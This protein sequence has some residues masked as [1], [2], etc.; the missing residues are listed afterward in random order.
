VLSIFDAAHREPSAPALIEAGSVATYADVA[1]GAAAAAGFLVAHGVTGGSGPI[2]LVGSSDRPTLTVLHALIALRTPALLV[3]PRLTEPEREALLAAADVREFLEPAACR[4]AAIAAPAPELPT[5]RADDEH[6]LAIVFTSGTT[7]TP[8]GVVLS[9]RSF[10]ASARASAENL[11]WRPDDRWLLG[12]GI[13]HVGGLGIVTRC[14]LARR[15][16]V[17][18]P[19][20]VFD[21]AAIVE[22]I[23][24]DRVTLMS[25]VPTQLARL[26]DL[27]PKWRPP[28]HL[29]AL[30][31]GGAAAP[32]ALLERARE[33][34]I[35]VLT[36]YGSSETCSQVTTQRLGTP[37]GVEQGAGHPLS[38]I[39]VAIVDN[40]IRVRG[41][42]LLSGYLSGEAA[43]LEDG[44]LRT[45]DFGQLDAEGRLHVLGR[46]DE[47]IVTGGEKVHPAEVERVLEAFAGVAA[48]CAC[49]IAD[50]TWGEIV[51]AAVVPREGVTLDLDALAAWARER[52][53]TFKRPRQLLEVRELP[54]T[55][56]GKLD[57]AAVARMLSKPSA[58]A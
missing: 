54:T 11:G 47:R 8:R 14:L 19:P 36:T 56:Q 2:A 40:E 58:G 4:A 43:A 55:P 53:A 30:L 45:G 51:G 15:A 22:C 49:G 13:S 31:L 46:R 12:L 32:G 25:L 16:V 33:R 10:V 9:R 35:P 17:L 24:R 42:I 41:P 57:R 39:D 44:W 26:L 29:R 5:A 6:P 3:H 21:P 38:G 37:C 1:A 7:G 20:G 34:G 27:E 18:P 28:P 48:A 50:P 52:L 23:I